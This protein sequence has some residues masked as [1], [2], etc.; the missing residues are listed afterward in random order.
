MAQ[1]KYMG[2]YKHAFNMD[3]DKWVLHVNAFKHIIYLGGSSVYL[4]FTGEKVEAQG[5]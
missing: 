4:H 2:T 3:K 5:A 1:T